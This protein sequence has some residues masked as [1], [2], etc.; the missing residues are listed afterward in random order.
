MR[1]GNKPALV[2]IVTLALLAS[3]LFAVACSGGCQ[4][5]PEPDL[6]S[7][8]GDGLRGAT[9]D[10][11]LLLDQGYLELERK[12]FDAAIARADQV[13]S[14]VSHG[15]GSAEALYLKGRALEAKNAAGVTTTE[16]AANLQTA[17][18]SYIAALQRN[19]R[20]PLKSYIHTSLGNVAYF[21]DDYP[22]A[23][24][25]LGTAYERLESPETRAWVLYRIGL[26]QQRQ[27]Q[28]EEADQTFAKVQQV[29]SGTEPAR[30]ATHH[31]GM[32]A[33]F[34]Q[35]ATFASA[36]PAEKAAADL[37]RQGVAAVVTAGPEGRAYL[38]IGP[39]ASYGQ[40]A[41]YRTR[42]AGK[43]PNALVIP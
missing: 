17:R 1:N 35:L 24:A 7:S 10:S 2:P 9:R 26:S 23:A 16:A 43:Y 22:A 25:Q 28:F 32:R 14:T 18:E 37:K 8:G 39:I 12:Q 21:Q 5:K 41:Y 33:F 31:V 30:R 36:P 11:R 4:A 34:V 3:V 20:E 15:E 19:P 13:L 40:A 38:R 27:G 42:F 6:K 29:H